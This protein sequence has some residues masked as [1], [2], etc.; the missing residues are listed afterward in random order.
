MVV[1]AQFPVFGSLVAGFLAIF[2]GFL[3]F[4]IS[5][6]IAGRFEP[7]L[8]PAFVAYGLGFIVILALVGLR[9]FYQPGVTT[10]AIYPD[11]IEVEVGLLNRR[12]RTVFLDR[13]IDVQLTE[14]ILQRTVG[15]GSVTLVTQ[16][17]VGQGDGRLSSRTFLLIN[18]PDPVGV[19]ELIR[20]LALG[21]CGIKASLPE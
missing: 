7:V 16:Q 4:V 14:G 5:N 6:M 20:S 1:P 11:R 3:T 21:D 13:I 15:A 12:R 19:Y 17:L 2:P 8:G 9:A 10:Y 18:V